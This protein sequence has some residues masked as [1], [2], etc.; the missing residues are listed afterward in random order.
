MASIHEKIYTVDTYNGHITMKILFVTNEKGTH[1]K[2]D[3]DF[4]KCEDLDCC[5]MHWTIY[6]Y[7]EESDIP[8]NIYV[9]KAP[10]SFVFDIDEHKRTIKAECVTCLLHETSM[11]HPHHEIS[12]SDYIFKYDLRDIVKVLVKVLNHLHGVKQEEEPITTRCIEGKSIIKDH[13]IDT[14]IMLGKWHESM[15]DEDIKKISSNMTGMA[16]EDIS[17]C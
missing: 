16:E 9:A 10:T 17:Y 15:T 12:K 7:D 3:N 6:K 13:S 5:Y 4:Y 1:S 14:D 2:D 11:C 8:T